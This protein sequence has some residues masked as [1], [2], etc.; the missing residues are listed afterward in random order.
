VS[1]ASTIV[2]GEARHPWPVAFVTKDAGSGLKLLLLQAA[3]T[4]VAV[5]PTP[6]TVKMHWHPNKHSKY[7]GSSGPL[8]TRCASTVNR[9]F[10]PT[11]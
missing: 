4:F 1:Q 6:R 5:N 7:C 10:D 11:V 8:S 2:A 3:R 9:Y